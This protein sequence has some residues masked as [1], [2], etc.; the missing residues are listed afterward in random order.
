MKITPPAT[1]LARELPK[2]NPAAR[3]ERTAPAEDSARPTPSVKVPPGLEKVLAKFEALGEAGRTAGQSNAMDRVARN[4]ARY[5]DTQALTPPTPPAEPEVT[6]GT[7]NPPP[8]EPTDV[9]EGP[10]DSQEPST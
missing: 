10:Q 7:D 5:T 8:T 1:A 9:A 6:A 3:A 4:L 2:T